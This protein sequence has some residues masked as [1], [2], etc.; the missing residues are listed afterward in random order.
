MFQHGG[1]GGDGGGDCAEVVGGWGRAEAW[2]RREVIGGVGKGGGAAG[3]D[4]WG[5]GGADVVYGVGT[6]PMWSARLYYFC[7]LGGRG[8]RGG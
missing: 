1:F 7:D 3:G 6:A 5:G 4:G 8:R 2:E